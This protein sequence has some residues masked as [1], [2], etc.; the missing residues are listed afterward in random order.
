MRLTALA[1]LAL[2]AACTET[3][4]SPDLGGRW[5]GTSHPENH[6][7]CTPPAVG[8]APPCIHATRERLLGPPRHQ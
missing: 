1:C 8:T 6:T 4:G 2:V 3:S 7:G 5:R